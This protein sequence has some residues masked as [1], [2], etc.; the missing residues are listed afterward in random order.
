MVCIM[1]KITIEDAT[2]R[3]IIDKY[4]HEAGVRGLKKTT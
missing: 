1:K 3:L 4:T 2:L